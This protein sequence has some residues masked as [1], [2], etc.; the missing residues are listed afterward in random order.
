MVIVFTTKKNIN[1]SKIFF[2]LGLFAII[3]LFRPE[4]SGRENIRSIEGKQGSAAES[5]NPVRDISTYPEVDIMPG[6]V[7]F[8][9]ITIDI[10]SKGLWFGHEGEL[11]VVELYN[12]AGV[13]LTTAIM[14]TKDG[15]W[16]TSGPARY[17]AELEFDPKGSGQGKLVFHNRVITDEGN[18]KEQ[19]FEIPVRFS[20][21]TVKSLYFAEKTR[22]MNTAGERSNYHFVEF[23]VDKDDNVQGGFLSA[24]YGTDG[25]RGS[26]SG[27]MVPDHSA[28]TG[29]LQRLGEGELYEEP[30][31]YKLLKD[32]LDLGFADPS[33]KPYTLE[34]LD[35]E[36]F[37]ALQQEYQKSIFDSR[38]NTTD[39]SRLKKIKELR[40][41]GYDEKNLEEVRFLE[42][43]TYLDCSYETREF[44]LIVLDNI[45]CGTGGCTLFVVNEKGETLSSTSVVKLPVYMETQ[46]VPVAGETA[47]CWKDLYVWSNGA[48]RKLIHR[49]GKYPE[50][51]SL[52]PRMAGENLTYY[53]EK[54]IKIL[55]YLD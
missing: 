47:M 9:P 45:I 1:M 15:N 11:G 44:I 21:P 39:R 20:Q 41:F 35:R 38:V 46:R 22:A 40:D 10:N 26:F 13:L 53:P 19:S 48:Y 34:M 30:F 55:D 18:N 32:K 33:G 42:L 8:S 3:F 23:H 37:E 29:E 6:Q 52:V 17:I 49:D 14:R 16:M 51:A 50:N 54:Y 43:E 27:R 5:T 24:P 4:H 7:I 31:S 12:D 25:S 36:Q 2:S 28:V